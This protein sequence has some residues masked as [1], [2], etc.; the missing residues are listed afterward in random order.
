[1]KKATVCFLLRNKPETEVLL[2]FKKTGFGAGKYAGIG[3]RVETNE[4]IPQAAIR[5]VEEEIGV[6]ILPSDM[7]YLGTVRFLFP[8]QIEWSQQVSIFITRSWQGQPSESSEMSPRWFKPA[9][10]PYDSMWQD[11]RHWLPLVLQETMLHMQFIFKPDN[12]TV[13]EVIRTT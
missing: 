7:Q 3:G 4:T 6:K 1:M 12:E 5:E 10:I 13:A 2:G 11:A 8:A 9:E